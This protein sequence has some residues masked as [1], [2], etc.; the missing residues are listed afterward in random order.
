MFDLLLLPISFLCGLAVYKYSERHAAPKTVI[1]A[2]RVLSCD[3]NASSLACV[4]IVDITSTNNSYDPM[5]DVLS[6][7][8][9]HRVQ[10]ILG[11]ALHMD[12][13]GYVQ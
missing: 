10:T 5:G 1:P 2:P 4:Q 3:P 9:L 8:D 11:K 13:G 7:L 12:M 6:E